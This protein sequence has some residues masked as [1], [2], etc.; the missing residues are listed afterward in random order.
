[1]QHVRIISNPSSG[2]EEGDERVLRLARHLLDFGY[3]V[4]KF[5]TRNKDDAYR[6]ALRLPTVGADIVV[7]SGGDGTVNEVVRGLATLST[8]IPLAIFSQGTVNDF[9]GYLQVPLEPYEMAK[10]I[11]QGKRRPV[12]IGRINDTFFVN[13]ASFG[14]VSK[15]GHEVD[16][17]AKTVLGRMA[18]LLEGVRNAPTLLNE[19]LC[20][21]LESPD[22]ETIEEDFLLVAISNSPS[23]GGF[24]QFAPSAK[25]DDG[26]LDVTCIRKTDIRAIGQILV[27]LSAGEH[28][29]H[30]DVLNFQTKSVRV[31]G[32]TTIP[33]DIDGEEGGDLPA[34]VEVVPGRILCISPASSNHT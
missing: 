32:E 20:L 23:V 13:V 31:E 3:A 10:M 5:D 7:A 22:F 4:S 27:A 30:P 33:I 15:I 25:I 2:R 19:P 8:Q 18:Y 28:T 24:K 29:E 12:D 26:L 21:R 34:S 14:H 16:T 11:H 1:M 9:A 17:V 6:E